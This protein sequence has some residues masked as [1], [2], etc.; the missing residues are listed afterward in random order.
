LGGGKGYQ[1]RTE[2]EFDA[3]LNAAWSDRSGPTILQVHI[4]P[5][6]CSRAMRRMAER[7]AK[8]IVQR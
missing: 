5:T 7:M 6:D 1:V 8:T 2:G 4:D 3:A